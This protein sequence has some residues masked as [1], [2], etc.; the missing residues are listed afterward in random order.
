MHLTPPPSNHFGHNHPWWT[1]VLTLQQMTYTVRVQAKKFYRYY[2]N[3]DTT[4]ILILRVRFCPAAVCNT[5]VLVRRT[6]YHGCVIFFRDRCCTCSNKFNLVIPPFYFHDTFQ[7]RSCELCFLMNAFVF[8]SKE[9]YLQQPRQRDLE[10][11]PC[12]FSTTALVHAPSK[13]NPRVWFVFLLSVI[14]KP[15]WIEFIWF[16]PQLW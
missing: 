4:I 16:I 5:T 2:G 1:G 10:A 6:N 8:F 12:E 14:G 15:A 9:F 13:W 11:I 7:E 3:F